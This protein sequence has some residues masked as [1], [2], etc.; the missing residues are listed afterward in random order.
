MTGVAPLPLEFVTSAPRLAD[1]P[2]NEAEV[3][4]VGRSNVGKSSLLN[5]LANRK[6][7]AKTSKTPGRTQ[8]LNCFSM[9]DGTA[10]ID[11]PG[12]GFAKAPAAERQRWQQMM[13]DYLLQREQ[14]LK[15]LVLVDGEVGPTKLDL[16]MLEWVRAK[17][18]PFVVIA[19]K[20]DKVRAAKRQK[21][22]KELVE[23]CGVEPGEVVWVSAAKGTGIDRLRT[24]VREWLAE[25]EP[26]S[27]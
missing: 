5:A 26:S 13:E 15:V 1:L 2:D 21:R 12:Y 4:L 27:T 17:Q 24:L 22:K 20:H 7:L 18:I 6:A 11:C 23:R 10:V 9:G 8:L 19:T 14:M 16:Q 3:A 25:D